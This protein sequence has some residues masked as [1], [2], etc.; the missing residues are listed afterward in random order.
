[1]IGRLGSVVGADSPSPLGLH[2]A[3][4]RA[5]LDPRLSPACF[6]VRSSEWL[7]QVPLV[8]PGRSASSAPLV[9]VERP[10]RSLKDFLGALG[11]DCTAESDPAPHPLPPARPAASVPV[12]PAASADQIRRR[13]EDQQRELARRA[14]RSLSPPEPLRSG[15]TL[16]SGAEA[17]AHQERSPRRRSSA[18]R[19]D[20]RESRRDDRHDAARSPLSPRSPRRVA[21]RSRSRDRRSYRHRSPPPRSSRQRSPAR[22]T[23]RR[24]PPAPRSPP[25]AKRQRLYSPRRGD[26]FPGRQRQQGPSRSQSPV[27]SSA[28]GHA[29]R[30]RARR[31]RRGGDCHGGKAGLAPSA[32]ERRLLDRLDNVE[33]E[34]RRS[35]AASASPSTPRAAPVVPLSALLPHNPFGSPARSEQ[36][37]PAG[38]GF[39]GAGGGPPWALFAPPRPL[40]APRDLAVSSH[41]ARVYA[42]LPPMKEVPTATLARL[43][44]LAASLRALSGFS[45]SHLT[46][47][48]VGMAATLAGVC[49][50]PLTS[51][52][53]LFELTR[54]YRIILPLMAA[55]G[56]AAWIAAP[57]TTPPSS[58]SPTAPAAA[59][60]AV[61]VSAAAAAPTLAL[62]A[63]QQSTSSSQ[64]PS[65]LEARPT[66]SSSLLSSAALPLAI[67]SPGDYTDF[68]D[69]SASLDV[70]DGV[71]LEEQVQRDL[72]VS[73][74]MRPA[75]SP[76]V[77]AVPL[78]LVQP[79]EYSSQGRRD[80]ET[81]YRA[82]GRVGGE[83]ENRVRAVGVANPESGQDA[84]GVGEVEYR[85]S[86][87]GEAVAAMV[88]SR[89]WCCVVVGD[90]GRLEGLLT[91]VDVQQEVERRVAA[92]RRGAGRGGRGGRRGQGGRRLRGEAGGGGRKGAGDESSGERD[93]S[94]G[95][96]DTSGTG[97]ADGGIAASV[98]TANVTVK[99]AV[100]GLP[101]SVLCTPWQQ[102]ET[103]SPA[104]SLYEARRRLTARGIRQ[105]PVVL[106][107]ARGRGEGRGEG[108]GGERGQEGNEEGEDG[109]GVERGG[110]RE[111][112]DEVGRETMRLEDG[113]G[114]EERGS[115]LLLVGLLDRDDIARACRAE[116]TKR[117]L[118]L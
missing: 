71:L 91:L 18:A 33:K 76:S 116:A 79:R 9:A 78:L 30:G 36:P 66:S 37:L 67:T 108:R 62:T 82:Q 1:M 41:R 115:D 53:L 20:K 13:F 59:A 19:D 55:V 39:V 43:W 106:Q 2:S 7:P 77:A 87:V 92:E 49:Q 6:P 117:L 44:S 24:R 63:E 94:G 11:R 8:A 10:E 21:S 64:P 97:A 46:P 102:L 111:G 14:G 113:E 84:S 34:L 72:A 3:V 95:E 35:R 60:A 57:A 29:R 114:R 83:A 99:G 38:T 42:L 100:E 16:R 50:V 4:L 81:G 12:A 73:Q 118:Q 47:C 65:S 27:R 40:P 98:T 31:G 26:R 89:Q 80:G 51:V 69:D 15:A 101:V 5:L 61:P 45:R 96:G 103:I 112:M 58:P 86:T 88:A 110:R 22:Q 48:Q 75:S 90:G 28:S 54:D 109:R 93:G 68:A 107:V 104:A 105:L 25:P 23:S 70:R 56:I 74:A 32:M 17:V 52:L 85:P